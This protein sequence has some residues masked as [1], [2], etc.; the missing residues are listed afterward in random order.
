[1]WEIS[2]NKNQRAIKSKDE[3]I[4]EM[5]AMICLIIVI[6]LIFLSIIIY[7]IGRDDKCEQSAHQE[8]TNI[9]IVNRQGNKG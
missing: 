5:E 2:K 1:M 8:S 9:S 6:V 4:R 7:Y 3:I